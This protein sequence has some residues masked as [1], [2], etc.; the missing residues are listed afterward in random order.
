MAKPKVGELLESI[1]NTRG[2]I[3]AMARAYGRSRTAIYQWI[4]ANETL[5]QAIYDSR[6]SMVDEAKNLLYDEIVDHRNI[7]A[8]FYVLNNAPEAKAEGWGPKSQVEHSGETAV[9]I[10]WGD[11]ADD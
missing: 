9:R 3:S 5:K 8:A 1:H 11:N 2:N 7:N 4:E 10:T 6:R